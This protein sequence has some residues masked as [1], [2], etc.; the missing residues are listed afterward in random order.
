MITGKEN[1]YDKGSL[2]QAVRNSMSLPFVWVPAID[3]NG[4]YVLDGG[5][6]NNLP[7]MR[8]PMSCFL[9][10]KRSRPHFRLRIDGRQNCGIRGN[11]KLDGT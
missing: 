2:A 8:M 9:R 4:H 3:D 1:V 10:M 6:T 7:S 5:L 11:G